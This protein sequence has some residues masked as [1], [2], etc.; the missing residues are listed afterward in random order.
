MNDQTVSAEEFGRRCREARRELID[1]YPDNW[2]DLL[3][4]WMSLIARVIQE[5]KTSIVQ[6]SAMTLLT[7]RDKGTLTSIDQWM[8][9]AATWEL[10]DQQERG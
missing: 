3:A 7:M 1:M 9:L 5:T 4:P 10:Y 8:I 6:A 2:R